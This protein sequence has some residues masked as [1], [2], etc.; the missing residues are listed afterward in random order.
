MSSL[1]SISKAKDEGAIQRNATLARARIH[2]LRRMV[3]RGTGRGKSS[4]S[5]IQQRHRVTMQVESLEEDMVTCRLQGAG[6]KIAG[7]RSYT[8]TEVQCR[9]LPVEAQCLPLVRL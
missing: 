4:A 5:A 9:R 6:M 2:Q 1:S 8:E 3:V 7:N